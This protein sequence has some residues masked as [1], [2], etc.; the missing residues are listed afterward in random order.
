MECMRGADAYFLHEES[1]DRHMHTLKIVVVDPSSAREAL[2]FQR[3]RES[4]ARA[5]TRLPAFRCR[6]LRMPLG[7]GSPVWL[8]APQIDPDYHFRHEILPPGADDEMLDDLAGRIASEPLEETRPLWQVYFVEGLPEGRKAY[9]TKIH[10]AVAD[11]MASAQLVSRMFQTTPEPMPLPP[12]ETRA[13]EAVPAG[14]RLLAGSLRRELIRQR[15]LPGLLV[16][17]ARA[18][19][20]GL[21]SRR[22]GLLGPPVAL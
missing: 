3:V 12:P 9:I 21:E 15:D 7:I 19:R 10:H 17:S 5:M 18:V 6:P 4:A 14:W 2:T 22:K 11:G 13:N 8:D 1:R 16:R 20:T